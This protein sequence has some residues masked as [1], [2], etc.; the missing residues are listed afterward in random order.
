[1]RC[2]R[3]R[4]DSPWSGGY[5]GTAQQAPATDAVPAPLNGDQLFHERGC[6]HCHGEHFAGTAK[7]PSLLSVG[8]EWDQSKI[9]R[10]IREG[11]GSMPAFGEVLEAPEVRSLVE[12][13]ATK[14]APPAQ[15]P[16]RKTGRGD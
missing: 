7:G 11:G 10:Q 8:S 9:E 6:S 4:A 15:K 1:M 14:K 2:S 5:R 16:R 12:L 13:L 3:L